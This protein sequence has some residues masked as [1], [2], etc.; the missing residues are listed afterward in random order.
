MSVKV[1]EH[2]QTEK[3]EGY[4]LIFVL[5]QGTEVFTGKNFSVP[6]PFSVNSPI[7]DTRLSTAL[8]A[9][10]EENPNKSELFWSTLLLT[11]VF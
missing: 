3:D 7:H 10:S 6:F 8:R 11:Q 5:L 4:L 1:T 9:T 2:F